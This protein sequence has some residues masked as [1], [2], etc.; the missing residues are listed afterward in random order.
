ME[1][2]DEIK[3][4]AK[5]R[6]DGHM[7]E[8]EFTRAKAQLLDQLE[9]QQPHN[10]PPPPQQFSASVSSSFDSIDERTWA[11]FIHLGQL[12][13]GIGWVIPIVIWQVKKDDSPILD[14]HGKNV[15]NWMISALIYSMVSLA[16]FFVLIG[17]FLLMAVGI[18][19][20]VFTIIG[21][22][23]AYEG[24]VWEYPLAIKFIK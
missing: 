19:C 15:V 20:I 2:A 24:T 14:Q 7:S 11:L 13:P 3:K 10:V 1:I 16:L 6:A 4:L 12:A 18:L 8:D 21:S 5:L 22:I 17:F 9:A 23:K